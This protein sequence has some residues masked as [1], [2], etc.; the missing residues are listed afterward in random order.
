MCPLPIRFLR[1]TTRDDTKMLS[2]HLSTPSVDEGRAMCHRCL[3][4]DGSA[5]MRETARRRRGGE[6][7]R[8]RGGEGRRRA[9]RRDGHYEGAGKGLASAYGNTRTFCFSLSSPFN[10]PF[11][12]FL[13]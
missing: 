10:L 12:R 6:A 1:L 2:Y 7:A 3:Q 8:R 11:W 13:K 5:R 4:M 9:G